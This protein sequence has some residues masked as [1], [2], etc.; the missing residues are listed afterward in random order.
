MFDIRQKDSFEVFNGRFKD[1]SQYLN[2]LSYDVVYFLN[3]AGIIL[4]NHYIQ[5]FIM[6]E[7]QNT[8][9]YV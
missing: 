3:I 2:N 7:Q 4:I 6:L 9:D 5:S 8:R 1:R